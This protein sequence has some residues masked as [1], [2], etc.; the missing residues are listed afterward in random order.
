MQKKP[1]LIRSETVPGS[2]V[3]FQAQLV[4]FDIKPVFAAGA[5]YFSYKAPTLWHFP[6]R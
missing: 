5:V 2:P 1:E 4:I 3:G 6:C